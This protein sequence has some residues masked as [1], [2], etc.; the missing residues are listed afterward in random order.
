MQV[1]RAIT[2]EESEQGD[3][4]PLHPELLGYL[5]H[6]RPPEGEPAKAVR[7]FRLDR[8]NLLD[9]LCGEPP[10]PRLTRRA[11][12]FSLRGLETVDYL[13]GIEMTRQVAEGE[14]GAAESGHAEER[15]CR[16]GISDRHD[17]GRQYGTA[18]LPQHAG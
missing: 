9:V 8:L 4:L 14:D 7:P 5:E 15:R 17:V 1:S 16:A 3:L 6:H 18:L 13:N 11:L 2:I 12:S 10:D